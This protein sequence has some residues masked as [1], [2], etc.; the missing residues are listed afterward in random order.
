MVVCASL[1]GCPTPIPK[2]NV[3]TTQETKFDKRLIKDCEP[4]P[5]LVSARENDVQEW[6]IKVLKVHSDCATLKAKENA[7]IVKALNIK[8]EEVYLTP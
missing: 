5:T 6:S 2:P 3:D 1:A 4:L 8:A 7:E